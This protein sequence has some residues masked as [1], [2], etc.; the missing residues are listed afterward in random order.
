[1][2]YVEELNFGDTFLY[3]NDYLILTSDFKSSGNKLCYSLTTGHPTWLSGQT[4]VDHTPV[5]I[6][7]KDNNTIPIKT[8][9][10]TNVVN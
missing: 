6:L 1:M 3:H 10:K 4:I 8:T 7:D 5:Y 9:E 2:K